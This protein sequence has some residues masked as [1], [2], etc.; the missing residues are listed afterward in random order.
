MAASA[1]EPNSESEFRMQGFVQ[2]ECTDLWNAYFDTHGI[3]FVL[4]PSV[5]GDATTYPELC[6]GDVMLNVKQADGS[7]KMETVKNGAG[8]KSFFGFTKNWAVPKLLIP[9][10]EDSQK[11]PVSCTCWGKAVPRE[12]LYDDEFVKTWDLDFIYKVQRAVL[13]IH[14]DP[15]LQRIEP[16]FND[17]IFG[18]SSA[19]PHSAKL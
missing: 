17:D 9:L 11:R 16:K 12:H 14:S 13:A 3:D 1:R 8:K 10:G 18:T 2:A 6:R 7:Y 5:W 4:T 15:A 19:S